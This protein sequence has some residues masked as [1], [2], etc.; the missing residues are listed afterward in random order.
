MLPTLIETLQA[1]IRRLEKLEYPVGAEAWLFPNRKGGLRRAGSMAKAFQNSAEEAGIKK[2]I[3]P[4]KLRYF[5]N[6]A[7]REAGVDPVTAKAL[8]GHVT[9]QM[10]G[11]Y[12]TVRLDEKKK[13]M[14]A[15]G[16]TLSAE[17]VR[18]S[19]RTGEKAA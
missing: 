11:H 19:V 16:R 17:Q 14:E 8:T 15:V 2:K 18:T 13:A 10:R 5:F 6:D 7:L 9:D 4:H 1:H 3:T 12:S